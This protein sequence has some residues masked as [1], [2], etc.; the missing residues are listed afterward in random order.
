MVSL[1]MATL[2]QLT[3]PATGSRELAAPALT[4]WTAP[5][6]VLRS[7]LLRLFTSLTCI[8]AE[9]MIILAREGSLMITR[10]A[11]P[12]PKTRSVQRLISITRL[13]TLAET[14]II[15]TYG[16][17]LGPIAGLTMAMLIWILNSCKI[18]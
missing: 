2:M 4:Y 9:S 18:R 17:W 3:L 14:S 16:Q 5:M 11:G 12:G 6:Q 8:I 10:I 15:T 7:I 13:S 1:S